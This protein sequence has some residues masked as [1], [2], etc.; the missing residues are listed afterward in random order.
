MYITK[1]SSLTSES[2]YWCDLYELEEGLNSRAEIRYPELELE[3]PRCR[4]C[5]VHRNLYVLAGFEVFWCKNY[6]P[7]TTQT[8]MI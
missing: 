7:L 1:K 5:P 6:D 4:E 3:A 8:S 2:I